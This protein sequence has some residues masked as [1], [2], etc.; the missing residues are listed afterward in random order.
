M[1]IPL[2]PLPQSDQKQRLAVRRSFSREIKL[3]WYRH[4]KVLTHL[5]ESA[6]LTIVH[7]TP[8][9]ISKGMTIIA[10]DGCSCGGPYVG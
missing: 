3:I 1:R 5:L 7:E 10:T 9:V 8:P 6:D 4:I 2:Q